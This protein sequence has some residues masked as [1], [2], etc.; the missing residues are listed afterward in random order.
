MIACLPVGLDISYYIQISIF[1]FLILF[2]A[3]TKLRYVMQKEPEL[4]S[5][6]DVIWTFVK[7]SGEDHSNFQTLV[8][9]LKMLST[10]VC[11]VN[12]ISI[13]WLNTHK[14]FDF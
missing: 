2:L 12:I 9:F 10:L 1:C 11:V 14:T 13:L 3:P 8:A 6:N 5:G 4:L 7:F